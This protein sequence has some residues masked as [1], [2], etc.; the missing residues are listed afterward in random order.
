MIE[1]KKKIDFIMG[2]MEK[3]H[4]FEDNYKFNH[5]KT[6][7]RIN[8][9]SNNRYVNDQKS[10]FWNISNQRVA[11]FAKNLDLDT[12]DL[13]PYGIGETNYVQAWVLKKKLRRWLDEQLMSIKINDLLE[14]A[15]EYGSVVW[16]VV[17]NELELVDLKNLYF[18]PLCKTIRDTDL[19]EKH[20][21]SERELNDKKDVW[22]NIDEV[23][24]DKSSKEEGKW[25]I[26]EYFGYIDDEYKRV[27]AFEQNG[28]LIK[29]YE[30]EMEKEDNPYWD[31]HT[32]KY[33]GRW[34]RIGVVER[35]FDLQVR[36][37]ELV[38]QNAESTKIASLLLFRSASGDAMGNVLENAMNGQ[39]VNSSDLEQ[40]GISNVGLQQFISELQLI[41]A[42][43]DRICFTPEVM[44][45][46]ALPS[47]TP[48]RSLAALTNAAR[49]VFKMIR[50]RIGETIS[51]IL[52]EKVLPDV[53]KGWNRGEIFDMME[54]DGDLEMFDEAVKA[55]LIRDTILQGTVVT[56]EM[57]K[58]L[59]PMI[60]DAL[61]KN[62]RKL[63]IPKG[64][65]NFKYGI[66]FNITGEAYD[67]AQQNGARETALQMY[68]ANPA[69]LNSPL[70]REYLED[71]GI[72][73]YKLKPEELEQ[74][75]EQQQAMGGGVPVPDR[76]P[77]ALMSTIKGDNS[78]Q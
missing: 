44:T 75:A 5:R 64:F 13:M 50:E 57:I 78:A 19:V 46:E 10:I 1:L 37:N 47:G 71:N 18:N 3:D 9:Y 31:F 8:L 62:G 45:G 72:T 17:N 56:P 67:K 58:G 24:E 38:N 39:I 6:L 73:W 63:D 21:L 68:M 20:Y 14:T 55:K 11:H 33:R 66:K 76:K 40:I 69:I 32:S 27:V 4:E 2:L 29:L 35:L 25:E 59:D 28:K 74:M 53:V 49:S 16:K 77:D 52:K 65:F 42:Q 54:D 15:S 36:A 26:L 30:E 7:Q 51:Y 60:T 41:D 48:F 12:K 43:A 61:T 22:E 23:L 70:M 34:L